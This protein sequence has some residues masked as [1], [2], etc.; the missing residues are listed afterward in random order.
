M[1][2]GVNERGCVCAVSFLL[3]GFRFLSG[4]AIPLSLRGDLPGAARQPL[5]FLVSPRKVSK[6]RR[7]CCCRPSGSQ[8]RADQN[9]KRTTRLRLRQGPLLYPF[10]SALFWRHQKGTSRATAS[11]HGRIRSDWFFLAKRRETK[12]ALVTSSD[13]VA[14]KGFG[15]AFAV[16][17][18]VAFE[19]AVEVA[20]KSPL[21]P[22]KERGRKRKKKRTLS[23]PKASCPLPVFCPALLGTP[24]GGGDNG[25]AFFCLLFLAR[26]EK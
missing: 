21:A 7:P 20:V 10:W 16:A 15:L 22:P 11:L 12:L 9:G 6:R 25:V 19:V 5:T 24:E 26:Q 1:I 17:F 2:D 4:R 8:K 13:T 18:A 23:E 14:P 3:G